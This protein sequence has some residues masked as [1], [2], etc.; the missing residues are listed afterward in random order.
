M[1]RQDDKSADTHKN[2]KLAQRFSSLSEWP[3]W[4]RGC[5]RS[6]KE[7]R[8]IPPPLGGTLPTSI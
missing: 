8:K 4:E 1:T 5:S 2:D 6:C 7:A 3:S